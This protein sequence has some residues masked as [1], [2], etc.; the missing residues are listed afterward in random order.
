MLLI[1]CFSHNAMHSVTVLKST[2]YILHRQKWG[3]KKW[4]VMNEN[5]NPTVMMI[6][7][8]NEW[9]TRQKRDRES[10][11][12]TRWVRRN[13]APGPGGIWNIHR[14]I[15]YSLF[16]IFKWGIMRLWLRPL[17][18]NLSDFVCLTLG[19]IHSAAMFILAV[20]VKSEAAEQTTV[21]E[22]DV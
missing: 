18:S 4:E 21:H 10:C 22:F 19:F 9:E 1:G 20:W 8:Q 13:G 16:N 14:N 12:K 2:C 7:R 5:I 11:R 3:A 17:R 6:G 15:N